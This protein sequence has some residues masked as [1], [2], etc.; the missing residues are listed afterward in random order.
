MYHF[1]EIRTAKDALKTLAKEGFTSAN[2]SYRIV[3]DL[4][5]N[6]QEILDE[7]GT[8]AMIRRLDEAGEP[9]PWPVLPAGVP[10]ETYTD[11]NPR[12]RLRYSCGNGAFSRYRR[13]A[14]PEHLNGYVY[15]HFRPACLPD[16]A[17]CSNSNIGFLVMYRMKGGYCWGWWNREPTGTN[18]PNVV[19]YEARP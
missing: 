15:P 9:D 11:N 7:Y 8:H 14:H 13:D 4:I 17:D 18:N 1:R 12:S 19:Y 6:A 10:C 2:V 3:E 5:D 16:W